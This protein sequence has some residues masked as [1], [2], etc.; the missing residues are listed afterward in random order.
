MKKIV[1]ILV[2]MG[3]SLLYAQKGDKKDFYLRGDYNFGFILQHHNN[4]GQLVNGFINGFELNFIKPTDGSK[5]WHHENNF[6]EQGVG[7]AF[8]NLDN[9]KQLGNVYA[10]FSFYEIPL[11]AKEKKFRLYMRL[12]P[13]LAYTPVYFNAIDNHKNN[14]VSS[15]FNAYVNFKWYFHWDISNKLRWEGGLNF[16]HASNGR[17]RVPNLGINMV[18]LNSGFVYKF[19]SAQKTNYT[20]VDSSA[21][22]VSKNEILLW[23]TLGRNQV[24][25]LGKIYTAQNY[26]ATYYHN[27]RNT[28]KLGAGLEV[29]YN[30]ANLVILQADSVKLSS[31]LQN[32]QVGIKFAYSYNAGRLSFPVEMGYMFYSKFTDDGLFFHRIGIRYYLKNNFVAMVTLKTHWAVASYFEFGA[33][34]RIPIKKKNYATIN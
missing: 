8:F 9:P 10:I 14:V 1:F 12:A 2:F 33:G 30:P 29:C 13:G 15:P 20:L 25:V 27:I 5:L 17:A 22:R 31:N 16:S 26:S 21:K 11:N 3:S 34:Y 32:T 7:F 28:H 4:M 6:P 24:D 18:T 23:F 19:L